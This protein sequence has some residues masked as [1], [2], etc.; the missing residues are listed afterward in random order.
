MSTELRVLLLLVLVAPNALF[1]VGEYAIVSARRWRLI[2]MA[3]GEIAG[4]R[5]PSVWSTTRCV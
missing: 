2:E 5:S 4:R 1:V 3:D